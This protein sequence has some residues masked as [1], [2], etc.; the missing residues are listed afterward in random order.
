MSLSMVK[1]EVKSDMCVKVLVQ[2]DNCAN[3]IQHL[4]ILPLPKRWGQRLENVA[5]RTDVP[6]KLYLGQKGKKVAIRR[7]SVLNCP[8]REHF[9]PFGDMQ[10]PWGTVETNV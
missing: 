9:R 3:K 5:F 2:K 6:S 8:R 7:R 4:V 10:R 1:Q